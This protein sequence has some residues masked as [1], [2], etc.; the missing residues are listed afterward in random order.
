MDAEERKRITHFQ[1]KKDT[2]HIFRPSKGRTIIVRMHG[3]EN[4][5]AKGDW[6]KSGWG[7][8]DKDRRQWNNGANGYREMRGSEKNREWA[9]LKQRVSDV[10]E[11]TD[12]KGTRERC[13]EAGEC[14]ENLETKKKRKAI[15]QKEEKDQRGC[16][17]GTESKRPKNG[18][19]NK[20]EKAKNGKLVGDVRKAEIVHG[21]FTEM[22]KDVADSMQLILGVMENKA[23][24]VAVVF[25]N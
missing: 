19:M 5:L 21:P 8:H 24:V 18:N 16:V 11:I 22:R 23:N 4:L 2:I 10:A 15:G 20:N 7:L 13:R 9:K 17:G 12:I 1:R 25:I 14:D 6:K 3:R